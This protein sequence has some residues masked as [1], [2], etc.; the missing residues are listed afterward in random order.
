M[1]IY[2]K[3]VIGD[4]EKQKNKNKDIAKKNVFIS[5]NKLVFWNVSFYL[6]K[7]IVSSRN[8]QQFNT[9]ARPIFF[10]FCN[11]LPKSPSQGLL[12]CFDNLFCNCCVLIGPQN[13]VYRDPHLTLKLCQ[14]R[15]FLAPMKDKGLYFF[16]GIRE[17]G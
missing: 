11:A 13:L 3:T 10:F 12:Q 6:S 1:L 17:D 15:G 5:R 7:L 16:D 9:R 14:V 8:Q 4:N 2:L